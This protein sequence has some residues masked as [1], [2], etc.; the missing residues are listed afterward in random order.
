MFDIGIIGTTS[1]GLTLASV[2]CRDF[3][4]AALARTADEARRLSEERDSP[5]LPGIKLPPEISFSADPQE[6]LQGTK[7]I[8][9]VVPSATLRKNLKRVAAATDDDATTTGATKGME[10]GSGLTVSTVIA[11]ELQHI[12]PYQIGVL[13]GPN[14]ALEVAEGKVAF[15]TLAFSK[16]DAASEL[17]QR[18]NSERFR[19]YTT[20]DIVGVEVGGAYKNV[21]AL[22]SG[23]IDALEVGHNSKSALLTRG[24]YEMMKFGAALG[25]RPETFSGL[26]GLGDLLAT[27][28]SRLS[29]NYRLGW[30]FCKGSTIEEARAE[31]KQV[32]EGIPTSRAI[33]DRNKQINLDLP[34]CETVYSVVFDQQ[35]AMDIGM[36]LLKRTPK[37]E[38]TL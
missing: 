6:V 31:I 14:L 11:G 20:S 32:V 4:V 13:S 10:A 2:F 25:A 17:Q 37:R 28:Y 18:L 38:N 5:L 8:F 23:F 1:W 19:I 26:S 7:T 27:C 3:K 24:L 15:T 36:K 22:A 16:I 33:I 29:R 35:N 12:A 21:I 9:I 30:A 34:I